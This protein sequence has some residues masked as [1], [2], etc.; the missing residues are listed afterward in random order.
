MKIKNKL[1]DK[2][3]CAFFSLGSKSS[4]WTYEA[5]KK[6]FDEVIHYNLKGVEISLGGKD[7]NIFVDG[8]PIEK[9]FDCVYIKGSYRYSTALR[10]LSEAFFNQAYQPIH[11]ASFDIGHDK[12]L[13]HLVLEKAGVPMPKTYLF[14]NYASVKSFIKTAQYP[15][16]VKLPRGTQGKGVIYIESF[17]AASSFLDALAQ[18]K[19]PF[20]IQEY[21]ETDGIDYR[22]L[23]IGEKVFGYK[24][25]A[26]G[27]EK[28]ANVHLGGS[29]GRI[30]VT[31][32]LKKIAFKTAKAMNAD[33]CAIDILPTYKGPLVIEVN[34]S[35]GLQGATQ[36]T[37]VNLAEVI[38]EQLYRNT[39]R[40]KD[41]QSKEKAN[42]FSELGI[43]LDGEN[44]NKVEI[45]SEFEFKGNNVILP[46]Y[47]AKA[48][49][50]KP[51]KN[52]KFVV[53]NNKLI[54]SDS[55]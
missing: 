42:L 18:L 1:S 45:I 41:K 46:Q 44:N 52:Y 16:I 15:L 31:Q 17:A 22:L 2:M 19:Q 49:R 26:N 37:G 23:V 24:R 20:L 12:I 34:L 47:I 39:V 36:A 13:T 8:K 3:R 4:Q 35:P 50:F 30:E 43:S 51:A 5:L 6:F 28:R 40:F 55:E 10:A 48:C 25:I 33:I 7:S 14:S 38:A 54:I 29:V 27:E 21:V 9:N 53:D 32:E 11:P